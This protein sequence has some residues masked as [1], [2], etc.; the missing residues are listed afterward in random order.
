MISKNDIKK[1]LFNLGMLDANI[2]VQ[3]QFEMPSDI[4]EAISLA[5]N[6]TTFNDLDTIKDFFIAL[7]AMLSEK[8]KD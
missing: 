8:D 5:K 3:D 2:D 6:L 4:L 7:F 1:I